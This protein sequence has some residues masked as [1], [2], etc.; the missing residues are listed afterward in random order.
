[1]D[2][3]HA[4]GILGRDMSRAVMETLC[5]HRPSYSARC[6][7]G[8]AQHPVAEHEAETTSPEAQ[9]G[10]DESC[11]LNGVKCIDALFGSDQIKRQYLISDAR[12]CLF[13]VLKRCLGSSDRS[14]EG[15]IAAPGSLCHVGKLGAKPDIP[16]VTATQI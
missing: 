6:R 14:L 8:F 13:P 10:V 15:D 3:P 2:S 16:F 1:M 11:H 12:H 9:C 5:Y 4:R 7:E